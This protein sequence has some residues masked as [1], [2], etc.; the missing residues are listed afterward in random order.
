[1]P[2][3]TDGLLERYDSYVITNFQTYGQVYIN[4]ELISNKWYRFNKNIT[5]RAEQ[6][7][8][9]WWADSSTRSMI[10]RC[11]KHFGY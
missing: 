6:D 8:G 3:K 1:M 4:I 9:N 2:Q 5:Y 10:Q 11:E 7:S